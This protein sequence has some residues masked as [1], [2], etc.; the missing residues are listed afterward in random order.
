MRDLLG[1]HNLPTSFRDVR[2]AFLPFVEKSNP[3]YGN[4][5]KYARG[6]CFVFLI[7]LHRLHFMVKFTVIPKFVT[8]AWSQPR[9][10]CTW[11]LFG[12]YIT[13]SLHTR[14]FRLI[15]SAFLF[16][17]ESHSTRWGA[18]VGLGRSYEPDK[19]SV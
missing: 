18:G 17:Q 13:K 14:W 11:N 15:F 7:G 4:M 8:A 2:S 12:P 19:L 5:F 9:T 10:C 6:R 1:R 16:D 3:K